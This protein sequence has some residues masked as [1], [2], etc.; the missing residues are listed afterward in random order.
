VSVDWFK[1]E[2]DNI[3]GSVDQFILDQNFNGADP[4][5]TARNK[6]TDPNAPFASNVVYDPNTTTY[7]SLYAPTFNLSKRVVEGLDFKVRYDIPTDNIGLFTLGLDMTHY[8]RFEQQNLPGD[9]WENRLGQFVDPSQGFGLGSLPRWKGNVNAFWNFSDLELGAIVYWISSYSDD[10]NVAERE[11]DDWVSLDLQASYNLPRDVRLTVGVQ[12]VTD[13]APPLVVGAFA[14][15]Y[16]RD[17]H[18][19]LGRFVYGQVSVKF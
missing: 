16:D 10:P 17:T 18:S 7:F 11:V 4:S 3:A 13:E 9:A 19:L 2:Q 12:N 6:P 1:I 8:Y 5:L 15:N 14:D